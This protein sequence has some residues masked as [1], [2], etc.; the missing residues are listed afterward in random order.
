[1][2]GVPAN[3]QP[4]PTDHREQRLGELIATYLEARESGASPHRAEWIARHPDLAVELALFFANDDHMNRLTEPFAAEN[5][6]E[7]P[8]PHRSQ[9]FPSMVVRPRPP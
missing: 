2:A 8:R 3:L 5:R 9:W 1:M 4:E 6:R 7:T